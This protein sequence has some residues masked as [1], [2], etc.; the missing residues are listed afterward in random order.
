MSIVLTCLVE[1]Y[2]FACGAARHVLI[3]LELLC[4]VVGRHEVCGTFRW[5]VSRFRLV[6]SGSLD[7]YDMYICF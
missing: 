2:P 6:I 1:L 4:S 5:F 3:F 7:L